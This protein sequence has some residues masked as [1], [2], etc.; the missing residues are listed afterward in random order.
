MI[1]LASNTSWL[2]DADKGEVRMV[3]YDGTLEMLRELLPK[4]DLFDTIRLD[5][6]NI[7]F[8]DDE[9]LLKPFPQNGFGICYK[10]KAPFPVVGSCLI[11][12][13]DG[14]GG[15]CAVSFDPSDIQITK[16]SFHGEE[17]KEG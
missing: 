9:G 15:H 10:D 5:R 13:D 16:I 4:M 1:A 2:L 14:C 7:I 3:E 11:T 17:E 12:G 6:N 8:V